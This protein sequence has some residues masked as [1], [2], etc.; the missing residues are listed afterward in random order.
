MRIFFVEG[1][2]G[3]GKSTLLGK[4]ASMGATVVYEPVD[5]WMASAGPGQPSLLE[6]YYKDQRR[7]AFLFQMT[8]LQSRLQYLLN[9]LKS[10]TFKDV[11]VCERSY[12]TDYHIFA[13]MLHAD[14][15]LDE[16]EYS[17]YKAWYDLLANIDLTCSGVIYLKSSPE[18]C[19]ERIKQR[20]RSGEQ[21]ITMH[22]LQ[23]LHHQHELW[24]TCNPGNFNILTVDA[25][26]HD[27]DVSHDLRTFLGI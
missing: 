25:D 24:L 19:Y 21:C 14:G 4:L 17:T 26:K 8:A 27:L 11:V 22:Y 16:L 2:I 23:K 13:C 3:V 9:I 10:P 5:D 20:N 1:N 7:Y 15:I 18:T 6:L 12:L